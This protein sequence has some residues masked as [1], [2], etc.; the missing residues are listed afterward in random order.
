MLIAEAI[1]LL[2]LDDNKGT[3]RFAAAVQIE[4]TLGAALLLELLLRRQ[5]DI[6]TTELPPVLKP[7]GSPMKPGRLVIRNGALSGDAELDS[8]LHRLRKAHG[9]RTSYAIPLAAKGA[10]GALSERLSKVGILSPEQHKVLGL[11]PRTVWPA[12][13]EAPEAQIREQ[14]IAALDSGARPDQFTGCVIALLHAA[15]ILGAVLPAHDRAER[16]ARAAR[17]KELATIGAPDSWAVGATATA[18]HAI[19][20]GLAAVIAA[21]AAAVG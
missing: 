8:A 18:I 7:D 16:K 3:V 15:G 13:S 20:T 11:F 19:T 12:R 2:A 4:S 5:I 9:K 10:R 21:S 17:A 14:I 6:T 1:L